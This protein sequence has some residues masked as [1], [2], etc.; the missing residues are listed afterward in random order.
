MSKNTAAPAVAAAAAD[1]AALVAA[2]ANA[3]WAGRLPAA[4][5]AAARKTTTGGRLAAAAADNELAKA[6]AEAAGGTGLASHDRERFASMWADNGGNVEAAAALAAG[7]R[8]NTARAL[9]WYGTALVV[10][11]REATGAEADDA[12]AAS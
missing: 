3:G 5:L 4:V 12:T 1:E 11:E 2:V 8:E 9:V 7:P 6:A 10:A